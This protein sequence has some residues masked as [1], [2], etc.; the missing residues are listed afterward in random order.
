MQR[1]VTILRL[2][3]PLYLLLAALTYILGAGI[4]RYLGK[5]QVPTSFWLGLLGLLL[6][7]LAMSLLAE[8]FRPINEQIVLN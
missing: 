5:P 8:V 4:A 7:L 6:T 2:S 1:L 3:R